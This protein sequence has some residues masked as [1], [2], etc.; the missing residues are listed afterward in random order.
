MN[1]NQEFKR[2]LVLSKNY[3]KQSLLGGGAVVGKN[4][5]IS[6]IVPIEGGNRITF[7][8]TLDNGTEQ[9]SELDVMNGINGQDGLPGLD[10]LPGADG[11]DGIGIASV[12]K[13]DSV[14][15]V[16]TYRMTFS[17]G[18]HLDYEVKNGEQGPQGVQGI[19]GKDGVEGKQGVQGVRGEKGEDGYPFLIYKEYSDISE[20]DTSDFPEIG[21]M[22]MINDGLSGSFPVYRYTGD[23]SDP[24]SYITRLSGGEPIKGETGAPGKDGE[25]GVPGQDGKDG[26]TYTPQ[27]GEIKTLQPEEAA[28]ASVNIDTDSSTAFFNFSIPKGQQGNQGIPGQNGETPHIGDNDHWFIGDNDTGVPANGIP[29]EKGED[30]KSIS[31]IRT[32]EENNV[33]VS[34]TDGTE[35]SI[36]KLNIPA[37][38]TIDSALDSSSENPVQNKAIAGK[39][40]KLIDALSELDNEQKIYTDTKIA[41]LING[42]PETLDTLKEV[43]D[44]IQENETIV[45]A[46]NAA[47]G[48]KVDKVA[49]KGLSTKDFTAELKAKLDGIQAGAKANVQ[50]D[51]NVTDENSDA[52]IK[53]KPKIPT[54]ISEL[55]DDAG[56]GSPSITVDT[57]MSETSTNPVQNKVITAYINKLHGSTLHGFRINQAESDP[58]SMIEYIEDSKSRSPAHMDYANNKFNY[59]GWEGEWF[60]RNLK[61]CMLSYGGEVAYELRKNDYEKNKNNAASDVANANFAGNAM[62]GVPKT[63]WKV[64]QKNEDVADIF[65]CDENMDGTFKCWSHLDN[66]GNEIP[67]CYMPIY[68]G[69]LVDNKLRSLSGKTLTRDLSTQRGVNYAKANNAPG[70]VIWYTDVLSDRMLINLLLLLIGK[71]TDTQTAFGAGNVYGTSIVPNGTMDQKGMFY[72]N[73]NGVKVFGLEHYWGNYWRRIAGW[74]NDRG[75]QKVKMTY[76][77][78]DGSTVTG[79]NLNGAGYVEIP[80]S[81]PSGNNGG[82]ISKMSF[83]D[84]GIFPIYANGTSETY[85][86]DQ[87]WFDNSIVSY[88]VVGGAPGYILR[89][90]AFCS[91][92]SDAAS[93]TGFFDGISCKPLA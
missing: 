56:F 41:D 91:G 84:R 11:Q 71:T 92:L 13:I 53:H 50:P 81:S 35:S 4:V 51:W 73:D 37:E 54:K 49:G 76:G 25:Q 40:Y 74:V 90:G 66:D 39:I 23:E 87:I 42:A 69:S 12:E 44:A 58:D 48:N 93:N 10:G 24:Y 57:E 21:L 36:G 64:V 77:Q 85:Y 17:D 33:I 78:S 55:T 79:Y 80:N 3:T 68:P 72:G 6:S 83:D 18:T 46:L 2:A 82:F 38:I 1:A 19:Q 32:D 88:A 89:A 16:D 61:P 70:D 15:L 59:G 22:F 52:F 45:D 60:I 62:V 9:T 47:I 67:Y 7:S 31:G 43:A 27:I 26:T 8:Y 5:K 20:F 34:F 28:S 30:G 29:G 75:V 65:F 14:G 63:F 86:A